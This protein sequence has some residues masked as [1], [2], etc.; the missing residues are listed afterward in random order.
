V[1][2]VRDG[3][4]VDSFS[5][6]TWASDNAGDLDLG[7]QGPALVNNRW[8][9]QA[10][11]S[12]T[13]YVLAV[14][15]LGGIGGQVWQGSVCRS[16]GGT[17]VVGD[18][19][20]VPCTDGI[21]AVRIDGSGQASIRWHASDSVAGSPVVGGG[22]VYAVDQNAGALVALDAATG[23][24]RARV[25]IGTVSRFATAAISGSRLYVPTLNGLAIVNPD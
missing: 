14:D 11:K 21:R 10:G 12:G 9:F 16:F 3:R 22:R 7:S 8:I 25:P 17:A 2:R 1:L 6:T 18:I 19:V 13:G 24:E 23:R 4:L 20:Y 15:R 5:P